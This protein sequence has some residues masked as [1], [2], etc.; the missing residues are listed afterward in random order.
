MEDKIYAVTYH[1]SILAFVH[2]LQ[3]DMTTPPS[4]RSIWPI[5]CCVSARMASFLASYSGSYRIYEDLGIRS[6]PAKG[7]DPMKKKQWMPRDLSLSSESSKQIE[8]QMP[9]DEIGGF[10]WN[11]PRP[12][13]E[14]E[15][16]GE[17][18]VQS[19][20]IID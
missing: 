6:H 16:A 5:I 10:R 11:A 9:H 14:Y 8:E 7:N 17:H 3:S 4:E 1:L 20:Q 12:G 19:R 15:V 2:K 13:L 18:F